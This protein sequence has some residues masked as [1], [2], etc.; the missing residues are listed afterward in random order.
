MKDKEDRIN[1]P[2][3]GFHGTMPDRIQ[4]ILRDGLIPLNE[5]QCPDYAPDLEIPDSGRIYFS[6]DITACREI[7][8]WI[9]DDKP[10]NIDDLVILEIE[11]TDGFF[12]DEM[13]MGADYWTD[14]PIPVN[15][16]RKI[17]R[18]IQ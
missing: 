16:I 8:S 15:R 1:L 3:I 11:I 18:K 12:V 6:Q 9:Y 5:I 14:K 10:G 13:G 2:V 4:S 7:C 17:H